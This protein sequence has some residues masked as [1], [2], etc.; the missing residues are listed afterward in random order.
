M[1]GTDQGRQE[2]HRAPARPRA[3]PRSRER[4]SPRGPERG[5]RPSNVGVGACR[6][7]SVRTL[8][9]V[10]ANQERE[11]SR[12]RARHAWEPAGAGHSGPCA[13]PIGHEGT[14]RQPNKATSAFWRDGVFPSEQRWLTGAK[15]S[16][17]RSAVPQGRRLQ[18]LSG[19]AR[20][21]SDGPVSCPL[22]NGLDRR[23]PSTS[24]GLHAQA[25]PSWPYGLRIERCILP[26]GRVPRQ[27]WRRWPHQRLVRTV[28]MRRDSPN[29]CHRCCGAR[30]PR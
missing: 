11:Q 14:R 6:E 2:A 12:H 16:E 22:P 27:R 29:S 18:R 5:G 28:P 17:C 25:H 23:P 24:H 20:R 9:V 13:Y 15:G 4:E 26:L 3:A 30:S 10:E 8:A 1:E 21:G 7:E 19:E